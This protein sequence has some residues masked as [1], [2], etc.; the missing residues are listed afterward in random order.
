AIIVVMS[1]AAESSEWVE[2]EILE[3]QTQRKTILP[4]LLQG[5]R[6]FRLNNYQY[7]DVR[8]GQ[9]PNELFLGQVV[10]LT[11]GSMD[12]GG[13]RHVERSDLS[14]GETRT[15]V[16]LTRVAVGVGPVPGMSFEPQLPV[17]GDYVVERVST[18]GT[19]LG[20]RLEFRN[21]VPTGTQE[22]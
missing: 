8:N 16:S 17:P 21:V 22:F 12:G 7:D 11:S 5:E 1:P 14:L 15:I 10:T 4:L 13:I 2:R 3:A 18:E 19:F 9:V 6:W 20:A